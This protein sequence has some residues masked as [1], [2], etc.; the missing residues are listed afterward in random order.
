MNAVSALTLITD[1]LDAFE[2]IFPKAQTLAHATAVTNIVGAALTVSGTVSG[3]VDPT[4]A[5]I[6]NTLSTVVS[7]VQAVRTSLATVSTPPAA[8][9]QAPTA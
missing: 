2:A 3:T 8:S 4:V 9:T 7:S 1:L 6:A 5:Q